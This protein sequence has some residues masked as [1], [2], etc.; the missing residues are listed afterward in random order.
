M[1]SLKLRDSKASDASPSVSLERGTYRMRAPRSMKPVAPLDFHKAAKR[2]RPTN[3]QQ[4]L[5]NRNFSILLTVWALDSWRDPSTLANGTLPA[6][7][8]SDL[9]DTADGLSNVLPM[10]MDRLLT[11]LPHSGFHNQRIAFENAV[12][13]AQLLNRTLLAPPIHLATKATR[14]M[15]YDSLFQTLALSGREGLH[16]C[17]SIPHYIFTPLECLHYSDSTTL[18]WTA[19]FDLST[20][21]AT[22]PVIY[23]QDLSQI[24]RIHSYFSQDA[25][26]VVADENPYQYRFRDAGDITSHRASKFERDILLS[27]L[28]ESTSPLLQLGSLF[29]SHRLLLNSSSAQIQRNIQSSM[30]LRHRALTRAAALVKKEMSEIYLGA[31]IRIGDG[32][33]YANRQKTISRIWCTLLQSVGL[34]QDDIVKTTLHH[35]LKFSFGNDTSPCQG[36]RQKGSLPNEL[37]QWTP[38]SS[39]AR[40]RRPQIPLSGSAFSVGV[41]LFISTDVENPRT[42]PLLAPILTT[43]PCTFF[44]SDFDRETAEL[45]DLQNPVDGIR[46]GDFFMPFLD[47]MVVANAALVVGT[48]GSTF[49]KYIVT[50]LWPSYHDT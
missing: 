7:A 42:H 25:I 27:E 1:L 39:P 37:R 4:D 45:A 26:V 30:V 23:L 24:A 14:F 15:Q 28:R 38:S 31:H 5:L 17:A 50:T 22:Q 47:A 36:T 18:P 3:H 19:L 11:Y 2:S 40:C 16:H 43:F 44:L 35:D 12:V 46:L 6:R 8:P 29:G 13:L 32:D 21:H 20:V 41:P 48:E 34:E 10:A 33:F 49:S 9:A